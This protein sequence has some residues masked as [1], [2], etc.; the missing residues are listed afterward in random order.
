MTALLFATAAHAQPPK[1]ARLGLCAPCH[2]E[3]GTATSK[4]IPHLAGQD[5][6]YLAAALRQYRNGERQAAA[7]R[8]VTGALSDGDIDALAEWYAAQSRDAGLAP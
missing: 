2:G 7:M 3:T 6:D 8:A 4:G 5:R 1:P